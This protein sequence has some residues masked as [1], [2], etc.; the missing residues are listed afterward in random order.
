MERRLAAINEHARSPHGLGVELARRRDR[1]T[2]RVDVRARAK[3]LAPQ[4]RLSRCRD[5]A[6][7]V[8][9]SDRGFGLAR[10]NEFHTL[11]LGALSESA[12]VIRVAAP[13]PNLVEWPD[14]EHR[15]DVRARLNA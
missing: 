9:A 14:R 11:A 7:D 5:G 15:I 6:D 10:D 13:E 12:C 1:R 3:P 2:D 4:H 8:R